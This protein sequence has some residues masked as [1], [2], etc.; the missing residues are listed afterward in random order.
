MLCHPWDTDDNSAPPLRLGR[1]LVLC[2]EEG[3]IR[4]REEWLQVTAWSS[5]GNPPDLRSCYRMCE[6]LGMA[7]K[8]HDEV[9]GTYADAL[10]EG[11]ITHLS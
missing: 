8:A 2:Q 10:T 3:N 7:D 9:Q 5:K 1:G 11:R 4:G 6:D